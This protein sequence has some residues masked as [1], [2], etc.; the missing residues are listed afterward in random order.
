[1]EAIKSLFAM[2]TSLFTTTTR[3]INTVDNAARIVEVHSQVALSNVLTDNSVA[4]SNLV[5]VI[6]Q[7]AKDAA[8]LAKL[9][10]KA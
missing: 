5:Q 9:S 6:E 8:K 10:A 2:F 1:M 7:E 3:V 4:L